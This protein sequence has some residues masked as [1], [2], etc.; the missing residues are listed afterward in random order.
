MIRVGEV[1]V[2]TELQAKLIRESLA[3]EGDATLK[4]FEWSEGGDKIYLR[5][6]RAIDPQS[7]SNSLKAIGIKATQVQPFG[8]AEEDTYEVTLVGLDAEIRRA[9]DAH[10]GA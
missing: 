10:F 2:V 8:R 1:S 4:K 9:L 7:L 5:Y 3:K 6:D